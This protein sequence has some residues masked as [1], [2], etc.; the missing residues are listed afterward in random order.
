MELESVYEMARDV[1]RAKGYRN[2][3]AYDLP[4]QI[5][6]NLDALNVIRNAMGDKEAFRTSVYFRMIIRDML[7]DNHLYLDN[8]KS[9]YAGY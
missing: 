7:K 8:Y 3:S 5:I 9:D 4:P 2:V 6:D 1:F